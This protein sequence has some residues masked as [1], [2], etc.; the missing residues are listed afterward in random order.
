LGGESDRLFREAL[1]QGAARKIADHP[2]PYVRRIEAAQH[3][4]GQ[5]G[6]R[7]YPAF[8]QWVTDIEP[9]GLLDACAE[10]LADTFDGYRDLLGHALK[11]LDKGLTP[12][13][14]QRHDLLFVA[15]GLWRTPL[16]DGDTLRAAVHTWLLEWPVCP[17]PATDDRRSPAGFG[18]A[19]ETLHR[20]GLSPAAPGKR[21]PDATV[22]EAWA[23]LFRH[24]LL[25]EG[26]LGRYVGLSRP[27]AKDMARW[28]AFFAVTHLRLWAARLPWELSLWD[29]GP[30]PSVLEEYAERVGEA[31]C[32]Q[33]PKGLAL[34]ERE[35]H[36]DGPVRLRALGLAGTL[37]HVCVG[38]FNEDYYRNPGASAWLKQQR[39]LNVGETAESLQERWL[40]GK[41]SLRPLAQ[42]L[43]SVM[44][45]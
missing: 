18:S 1:E 38:R 41:L 40:G 42:R 45:A 3:T 12:S 15:S 7:T 24:Q 9:A 33:F 39:A 22:L 30:R 19:F 16:L 35:P 34:A 31:L 14:A 43:L 2:G 25:D 37:H 23:T 11:K 29:R 17:P 8:R 5:W 4:A 36:L 10:V 20:V 27:Q 13:N 26:W 44:G 28:A 6:N 32:V 21:L